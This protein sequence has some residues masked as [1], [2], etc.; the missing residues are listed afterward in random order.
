MQNPL[1]TIFGLFMVR[2]VDSILSALAAAADRLE[3]SVE[4]HDGLAEKYARAANKF[5]A[6]RAEA[7]TEAER[8]H[9]VAQRVRE[10]LS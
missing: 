9:R 1:Y 6:M 10:L 3:K 7:E 5:S 2:R 8:A 4:Q